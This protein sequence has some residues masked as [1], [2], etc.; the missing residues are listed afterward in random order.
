MNWL[1]AAEHSTRN[2]HSKNRRREADL[3]LLRAVVLYIDRGLKIDDGRDRNFSMADWIDNL[4]KE[5]A[6]EESRRQ[7]H[8]EVFAPAAER[9]WQ[10]IVAQIKSDADKLSRTARDAIKTICESMDAS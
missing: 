6:A 9:K 8:E 10:E 5:R 4:N 2:G 1:N 7:H 3:V